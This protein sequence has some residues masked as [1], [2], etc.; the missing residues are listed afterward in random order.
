MHFSTANF[1]FDFLMSFLIWRNRPYH[2]HLNQGQD[3]RMGIHM[4]LILHLGEMR[5]NISLG[6]D[7]NLIYRIST[8]PLN[9][10]CLIHL[11]C[12]FSNCAWLGLRVNH[13]RKYIVM[14]KKRT[15]YG[16]QRKTLQKKSMR[17]IYST[18]QF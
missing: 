7:R 2:M 16:T 13:V 15:W 9:A 17:F 3:R 12:V 6:S 18:T 1:I 14:E 4:C 8:K 11:F 5:A 10:P